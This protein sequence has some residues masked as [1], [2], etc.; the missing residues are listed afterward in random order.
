MA[1]KFNLGCVECFGRMIYVTLSLL[2]FSLFCEPCGFLFHA[3]VE[4]K[5]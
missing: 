1:Q 5:L 2:N 4:V 3:D